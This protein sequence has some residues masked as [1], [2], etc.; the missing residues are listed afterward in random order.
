MIN[1]QKYRTFCQ[2]EKN[3]PLFSQSWWLDCVCGEDNWDIVL[4]EQDDAIVASM[5]YHT[6]KY[7]YL[8]DAILMPQMTQTMGPYIKHK[9]EQKYTH[10][11]SEEK[12]IMNELI[13]KLPHFD[14]FD[15]RFHYS[16]TNWQPFYWKGFSQTTRYTYVIED[17]SDIDSVVANFSKN[18]RHNI[19]KAKQIVE[20]KQDLSAKIFYDHHKKSL[21]KQGVKIGYRYELFSKIYEQGYKNN[22]AKAFYAVDHKGSIHTA[23]F[24]VWDATSAYYLI[25]SIDPDYKSS[26]ASALTVVEAIKYVSKYC[27]VFDFEGSMIESVAESF[28]QFGAV[29]KPYF[30]IYKK[31]DSLLLKTVDY[32]AALT[33]VKIKSKR[34]NKYA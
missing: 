6:K 22:A 15:Q 4:V 26:G 31:T 8:F 21:E 20:I 17:L 34:L 18:K 33:T 7:K 9:K 27:E 2:T 25:N 30:H 3:I 11:L 23:I 1:K 5:P 12:K 29:Q 13:E 28:R 32:V 10:K 14:L 24:I 19:K 16:V